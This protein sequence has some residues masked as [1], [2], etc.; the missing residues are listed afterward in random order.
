MYPEFIYLNKNLPFLLMHLMIMFAKYLNICASFFT[1]F[2]YILYPVDNSLPPSHISLIMNLSQRQIWTHC[3]AII[4][5]SD[6]LCKGRPLSLSFPHPPS[7]KKEGKEEEKKNW[8]YVT[9]HLTFPL[10]NAYPDQLQN[11]TARCLDWRKNR[12]WLNFYL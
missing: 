1:H 11:C 4:T 3:K 8:S 10:P 12:F 5:L 7:E 6:Y 2:L 9:T